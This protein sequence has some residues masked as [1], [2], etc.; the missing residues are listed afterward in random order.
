MTLK[1][2]YFIVAIVLFAIVEILKRFAPKFYNK[3][4]T[5]VPLIVAVLAVGIVFLISLIMKDNMG[6]VT[7]AGWFLKCFAYGVAIAGSEVLSY[8][9]ILKHLISFISKIKNGKK[10]EEAIEET[11]KEIKEGLKKS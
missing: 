6:T 1:L 3:I 2:I 10:T 4:K 11:A 8:E 9:A 7:A 5:F